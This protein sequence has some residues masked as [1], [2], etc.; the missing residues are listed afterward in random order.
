MMIN[1]AKRVL[2]FLLS[3][4]VVLAQTAPLEAQSRNVLPD[5]AN[6]TTEA[7]ASTTSSAG[8]ENNAAV[9]DAVQTDAPQTLIATTTKVTTSGSPSFVGQAVT[10]TATV[11]STGGPIPDGE[12]VRFYDGATAIGTGTTAGGVATFTTSSLVA[13]KHTIKAT[14]AGDTKFATSSGTVTQV[15]NKYPTTT[16]LVS[17]LNPTDFGQAVKYTATVTS[18]GPTPTGSVN[19]GIGT[20]V[21]NGGA[22]TLTKTLAPGTHAITAKY[23]GDT[24]SAPS[25]SSVLD[26]VVE[27]ALFA[28]PGGPYSGNTAQTITFNGSGSDAP[29]GQTIT[30][31]TWNFGDSNT[32]TGATPTHVYANPGTFTV[33]LTVKD[34]K[35]LTATN[36]T[37]ATITS[38]GPPPTI[39]GF[40]PGSGPEGTPVALSGTN[41]TGTGSAT[42]VVTLAHQGGGSIA[43]PV[44]N[45][46][47]T[48][49]N[50]VIPSGAATGDITVSVGSQSATSTTALTVTTSS[51]YTVGVAPASGSVIQGQSTTFSVTLSSSN[52]FTGLS[53]L[54]VTG[55]PGGVTAT[56]SPASIAVGQ[57]SIMTLSAPTSQPTGSSSLSVIASATIGGQ[58]VTQSATVSLQVNGISTTFLGRTVVDDPTQTPIGGVLVTFLGVDDKG[59]KT[60][61][62]AQTSSDASGNFVLTNLPAACIG[63]QLIAY[64]GLTATSPAG[65]FAGVNLSYTIVANQV[66]TSPVLIHLPRIDNAEINYITQ[67]ANVD[68]VFTFQ[69]DPRIVVTVYAGTT[70]TLDDGSMPNPFPLVAVEV[71]VDRL[72]DN[73]PSN[74]MVMPFIVAF[75]PANAVASQPVA[76]DFPNLLNIPPGG[77]ATLMTLD[78][79]HGYMVSYGT[80]SVSADASRIVP[81]PD[82]AHSGHLYGLVHFDWHGPTAPPPPPTGPG[83]GPDV[84]GAEQWRWCRRWRRRAGGGA[85][86]GGAVVGGAG[87]WGPGRSLVRPSSGESNGYRS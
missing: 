2:A 28:E 16:K 10:F 87:G 72:P 75:Q 20:V 32:G 26:E 4:A 23:L 50:F 31:Y 86:G 55:L 53:A 78:P 15:V 52:G 48:S 25:A 14:Y 12:T 64:N 9:A 58:L 51:S 63:P 1:E 67:N 80:G 41:F 5:S 83:P 8:D 35:G 19:F 46:T 17:S 21:L 7:P 54:S 6:T 11:T 60:G 57:T 13:K 37:T 18:S 22:A 38:A 3:Y 84:R 36:S 65:K 62:S 79:T 69:T 30:A 33:S 77:S 61:C 56:F 39:G 76:V 24:A 43:A 45:F 47:A 66:T 40:S 74:G 44:S 49:I 42:P 73:M 29:K 59:N 81:D 70:F 68:Q 71:P 27:A 85:G 34:T 82:P